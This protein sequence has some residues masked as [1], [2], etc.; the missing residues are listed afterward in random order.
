MAKTDFYAQNSAPA[1]RE[2]RRWWR[3]LIWSL[4]GL[5]ALLLFTLGGLWLWAGSEGS[6]ATALRW[7]GAQQPI[8]T[9]EVTGNI[10]GSG[11]VRRLVWEQ[12]GLRIEV[13]DAAL[14]WTPAALLARTLQIDHLSASRILV[15]DQRPAGEPSTGPPESI[16][17]PI[18]LQ[19]KELAAGELRW[20]G[21]PPTACRTW[22]AIS[23][24][25]ASATFWS[26]SAPASK[27]ATTAPAPPSP[28]THRSRWTWRWPAPSAR[29]CQA[30][31]APYR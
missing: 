11:K 18:K 28:R 6:L 8:V 27:A 20:A 15:D 14:S 31:T 13:H 9:E 19:V 3:V 16:A 17:L 30:P 22:P 29:R 21:P 25:T 23:T 1:M 10:R 4:A 24:T 7:A 26:W 5:L 2:R 12:G